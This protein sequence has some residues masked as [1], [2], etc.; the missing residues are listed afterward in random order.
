MGHVSLVI[1]SHSRKL[2]QGV[3]ELAAQLTGPSVCIKACGGVEDGE[4]GTSATDIVNAILACPEDS[5]VLLFF[6]IGSAFMNC[7][8]ALELVDEATR[9]RVQIVDAPLVE[10]AVEAAVSAGLGH[11]Q[12]QVI[13]SAR[14]A[15]GQ[16]KILGR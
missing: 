3:T 10:G 14:R 13:E 12:D 11:S 6:D 4:L 7:E 1:V 9:S 15:R 5:P 2:A 16:A 8:M